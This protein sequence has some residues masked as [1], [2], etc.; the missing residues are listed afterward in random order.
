MTDDG[1]DDDDDASIEVT[2]VLRPE[3]LTRHKI[4]EEDLSEAVL[5]AIDERESTMER[6]EEPPPLEEMLIEL[7]GASYP[8]KEFYEIEISHTLC[9]HDHDHD[10]DCGHDHDH[11][12][13]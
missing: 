9:D 11:D 7:G 5:A 6:G 3:S 2:F 1:V 4:S 12:E 13:P 10:H 8:C